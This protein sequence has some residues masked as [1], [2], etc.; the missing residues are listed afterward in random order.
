MNQAETLFNPRLA[1]RRLLANLFAFAFLMITLIG[2]VVLAVLLASVAG[3]GW[4][5]LSW[6]FLANPPSRLWP[7]NA[8]LNSALFGTLWLIG[9]TL[10]VCI[11]IGIGAAVYL[12]EFA[13]DNRLTRLIRLNIANLAGVPSVVYGILGLAVF[14]RWLRFDRSVLS[15]G[16]TLSLLVLPVVIIASREALAAVPSAVRHAAYALGATRWQTVRAHVLP[17]ALP[18]II[19]GL[20]L[21][22]SRAVGETAPLIM[23]GGLTFCTAVPDGLYSDFTA[24]PIQIYNW[25]DEPQTEFHHLAS[26]GIIVLLGVL[27]SMNAL[28]I[29]IR[30]WKQRKRLW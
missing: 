24:M 28:A 8:G 29:G 14:V 15:G 12:E 2:V 7:E 9:I 23:L 22:I 25:L 21:A 27:L 26:A 20:I 13:R 17:A 18:G 19:T 1:R 16:L 30:A 6:K 11:P 4:S 10:V 5:W 3:K